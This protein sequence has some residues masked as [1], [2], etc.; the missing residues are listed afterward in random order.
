MTPEQRK[1]AEKFYIELQNIPIQIDVCRQLLG[2]KIFF[3][4]N[5]FLESTNNHFV[6][7]E[8]SRIFGRNVLRQWHRFKEEDIVYI[9]TYLLNF[10]AQHLQYLLTNIIKIYC[11][12]TR[13]FN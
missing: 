6:M 2:K 1:E 8:V 9:C 12:K 4:L 7:F 5:L 11:F 3:F 13:T 10:P